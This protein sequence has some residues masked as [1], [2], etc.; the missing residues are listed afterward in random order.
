M[1]L[2]QYARDQTLQYAF[3]TTSLTRPTVWYAS[4]HTGFPGDTGTSIA[5]EFTSGSDTSYARQ[6]MVSGNAL[7]LTSH[8]IQNGGSVSWTAGGTWATATYLGV[9]D[10]STA[11]NLWGYMELSQSSSTFFL[12][13][14]QFANPGSGYAVND[15]I[16]LTSGGGA[17]LTVDTVTTTGGVSGIPTAVRISTHGS[18][19]SIPA[20]PMATTTSGS[21]SGATVLASWLLAPQAFQLNNGDSITLATAAIQLA[22]G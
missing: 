14:A 13:A 19:S 12:A 3:T 18:V 5:N 6:Q 9:C 7:A 17:V 21:G 2:S 11:G 20:N 4:L 16:T 10:A 15:T 1:P 8:I 22:M